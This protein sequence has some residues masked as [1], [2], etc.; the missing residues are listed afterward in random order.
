MAL[1]QGLFSD[2]APSA[3]AVR[4]ELEDAMARKLAELSN[5]NEPPPRA[6][7]VRWYCQH[8]DD[9]ISP[10]G[11][12]T[13]GQ[14]CYSMLWHKMYS[15]GMN[16]GVNFLCS[17]LSRAGIL[18]GNNIAPTSEHICRGVLGIQRPDEYAV[19]MCI[20]GQCPHVFGR[21]LPATEQERKQGER[22][23]KCGLHRYR[24]RNNQVHPA[25][26]YRILPLRA[27]IAFEYQRR[28][29]IL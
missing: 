24:K 29:S 9:L 4:V 2:G 11:T 28:R 6:F 23:P 17:W 3:E 13:V 18:A 27:F 21:P 22:C 20:R 16:K 26:R 12:M 19:D 14:Y 8:R 7:T 5:E 10:G 15:K 1:D 25:R